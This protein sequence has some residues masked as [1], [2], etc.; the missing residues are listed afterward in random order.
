M[1]TE[2]SGGSA[3]VDGNHLLARQNLIFDIQLLEVK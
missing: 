2:I 3:K 1:V